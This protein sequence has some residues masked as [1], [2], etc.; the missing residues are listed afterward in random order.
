MFQIK[1]RYHY[2]LLEDIGKALIYFLKICKKI[3]YY[4]ILN[5]VKTNN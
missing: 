3:F 4:F 1:L 5:G 2:Y